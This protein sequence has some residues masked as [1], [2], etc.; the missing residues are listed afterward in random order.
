MPTPEIYMEEGG[1]KYG[2]KTIMGRFG[3]A[4]EAESIDNNNLV[5]RYLEAHPGITLMW[6]VK[7]NHRREDWELRYG[8]ILGRARAEHGD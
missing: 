5:Y 4:A 2:L 6:Y 3:E 8:E 7:D 1:K